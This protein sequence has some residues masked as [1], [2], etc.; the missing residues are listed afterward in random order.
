[1]CADAQLV[2]ELTGAQCH[3][4]NR[5]FALHPAAGLP[6]SIHSLNNAAAEHRAGLKMQHF[7]SVWLHQDSQEVK[8]AACS[9]VPVLGIRRA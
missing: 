9:F 6:G 5:A 2:V 1:M 7:V 8:S 4:W 3:I